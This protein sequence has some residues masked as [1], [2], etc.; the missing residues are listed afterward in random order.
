MR[1][2]C[3]KFSVRKEKL[4]MQKRKTEKITAKE[5][6]MRKETR[7]RERENYKDANIHNKSRIIMRD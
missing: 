3:Q 1:H 6:I 2:G 5:K 4:S 7:E